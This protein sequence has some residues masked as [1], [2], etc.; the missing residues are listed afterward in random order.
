[1]IQV[2]KLTWADPDE[3]CF[4]K[5]LTKIKHPI[6]KDER[7][8]YRAGLIGSCNGLVCLFDYSHVTSSFCVHNPVTGEYFNL[9]AIDRKAIKTGT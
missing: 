6:S 7:Y 8:S 4:Y 1:M 2:L 3:K 5:K 9:P